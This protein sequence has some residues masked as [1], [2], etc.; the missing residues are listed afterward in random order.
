MASF[1]TLAAL[2][3][4]FPAP[5]FAR[6]FAYA[7]E[8]STPGTEVHARLLGLKP[9]DVGKVDLG[10]GAFAMEQA[11]ESKPRA[12]GFFESHRRYIDV[13]V[14]VAGAEAME[15]ADIGRLRVTAE[16]DA[17]RDLIKYATDV[18]GA[19]RLVVAAGEAAVFFPSD[20]HLPSLRIDDRPVLVRK[21][22][23]KLP[24][25]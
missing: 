19:S 20:G 1:G 6:A 4:Q 13:Q 14:V 18:P 24:V 8:A 23:V 5:D 22:V 25:A 12:E 11:Y 21:T 7:A 9:G 3:R 2:A 17:E 16:Y 15:V 10:G